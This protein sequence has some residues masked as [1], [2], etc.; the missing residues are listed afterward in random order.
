MK[1]TLERAMWRTIMVVTLALAISTC[2]EMTPS[3]QHEIYPPGF[4]IESGQPLNSRMQQLGI[5]LQQLDLS[6][7]SR[8]DQ[9][10]NLQQQVIGS[11]QEIERIAGF[12]QAGDVSTS[13]PFLR[14]DMNEF[15]VD[16]RQA[17]QAVSTNPPRYYMAGRITGKC[18]NC[19][20]ANR[21]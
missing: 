15:L 8:A 10:A 11:L 20:R 16:V 17:R 9:P 7:A 2:A 12:L 19:H 14:D 5:A 13:H 21:Q 1:E 6:L 3:V 18:I 4:D